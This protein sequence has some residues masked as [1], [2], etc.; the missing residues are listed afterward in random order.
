MDSSNNN[1]GVICNCMFVCMGMILV[2]SALVSLIAGFVAWII[3]LIEGKN[4]DIAD[5]CPNNT[6]WEWLLVFG[7]ISFINIGKAK[8]KKKD[9]ETNIC[10]SNCAFII[11]LAGNIALCWWGRREIDRDNG[12]IEY[13]YSDSIF[14]KTSFIFWW[15]Y[16]VFLTPILIIIA[17]ICIGSLFSLICISCDECCNKKSNDKD[18]F[19]E[20]NNVEFDLPDP[21]TKSEIGG[22]DAC[23]V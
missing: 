5:T 3:A 11:L 6:L 23:S 4:L 16:F 19:L 13:H 22:S 2:I 7:I 10:S 15:Y 14:Y 21:L 8:S 12:C 18:V 20:D 1:K 17:I 9:G